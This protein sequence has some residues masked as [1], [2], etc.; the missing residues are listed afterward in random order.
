MDPDFGQSVDPKHEA[1][2][3]SPPRLL[4]QR[5]PGREYRRCCLQNVGRHIVD[6]DEPACLREPDDVEALVDPGDDLLMLW[7]PCRTEDRVWRT[8]RLSGDYRGL[9]LGQEAAELGDHVSALEVPGQLGQLLC[10]ITPRA[11][12]MPDDGSL[13]SIACYLSGRGR[14]GRISSSPATTVL[15]RRVPV[16]RQLHQLAIHRQA[17]ADHALALEADVVAECNAWR[18][19]RL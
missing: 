17:A 15:L 11:R 4:R 7:S 6:P 16:R 3:S 2:P 10:A 1:L 9:H 18:S 8:G 14:H 19:A 5:L 13:A 12:R